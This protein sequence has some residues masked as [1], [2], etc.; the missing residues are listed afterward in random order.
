MKKTLSLIL[1]LVF[2]LSICTVS[3]AA[4]EK[5]GFQH[6]TGNWELVENGIKTKDKGSMIVFEDE[7]T[8]GSVSLSLSKLDLAKQ[9]AV[10]VRG[11]RLE[12]VEYNTEWAGIKQPGFTA[13]VLQFCA[14]KVYFYNLYDAALNV[15]KNA[16]YSTAVAD[17]A[18]KPGDAMFDI[19]VD[20]T[21][22][23]VLNVYMN[24]APLFTWD[25]AAQNDTHIPEGGQIALRGRSTAA[26]E[27]VTFTD[28]VLTLPKVEHNL[29]HHESTS[30]CIAVGHGEYWECDECGLIFADENGEQELD[31]IPAGAI[32]DNHVNTTD[33]AELKKDEYSHWYECECGDILDTNEHDEEGAN[34]ECSVCGY[35]ATATD[36][37]D[38]TTVIAIVAIV[39]ALGCGVVFMK[40][41]TEA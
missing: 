6:E 13:Y 29:I 14:D 10:F 40:T 26:E 15:S 30:N 27:Y 2:I 31:E 5:D 23:G 21:E 3:F 22:E 25:P 41:R 11:D 4:S 19:K 37:G 28:V 12:A 8:S 17:F 33:D 34:G 1:T 20:F 38:M 9:S 7:T 18:S 35:K 24:E 36:T 39:A 16:L 32:N